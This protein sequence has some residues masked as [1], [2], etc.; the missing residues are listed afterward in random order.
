MSSY[1]KE[2]AIQEQLRALEGKNIAPAV[3]Q[4]IITAILCPLLEDIQVSRVHSFAADT[5]PDIQVVLGNRILGEL[6]NV[7]TDV[8]WRW[9][10]GAVEEIAHVV[11]TQG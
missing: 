4:C 5:D 9:Q 3:M 1:T 8:R 7:P 6:S 2:E 11:T 10:D